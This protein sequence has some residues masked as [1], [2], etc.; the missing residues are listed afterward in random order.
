MKKT[1]RLDRYVSQATGLS[2]SQV[3]QL[4]RQ[5]RVS[6]DGQSCHQANQ[7][8]SPDDCILFDGMPL[9]PA[10]RRYFMLNKPAGVVCAVTDTRYRTVIS[11]LDEVRREELSPAGR[12]DLDTT[13][14]VLLTDDG[15][16]LHGITSPRRACSKTYHARLA[17]ALPEDA[18]EQFAKG[19]Q[20]RGEA[21]SCRPAGL[22]IID[23]RSV[24]V[25]LQEGRYHQVKRMFAALGNRVVSLHR[26]AIGPLQLDPSLAAGEYRALHD[27]EVAALR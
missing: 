14:L 5:G 8:I 27:D 4:L 17:E 16:W 18:V 3:R 6:V 24:R 12:L 2:R 19:L 21:K 11:L 22:E 23:E 15:D 26:E 20:L 10:G 25:I 7:A 1:Q 13:G 9:Q